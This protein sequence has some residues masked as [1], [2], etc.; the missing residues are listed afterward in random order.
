MEKPK[1]WQEEEQYLNKTVSMIDSRIQDLTSNVDK[2]QA[3]A[4]ELKKQYIHDLPDFDEAEFID[5]Y[6]K[7]DQM[8]SFIDDQVQHARQLKQVRD[9][10][11]FGRIDFKIADD[12]DIMKLYI[13]IMSIDYK[14][15]LYVI[16]W[17]APVSELF[18]EAGRGPASYE[19]P[20][21]VINGEIIL[22]RQHDIEKGKLLNVYD[23]NLNIFDEFL[24]QVLAKSKGE[25]LQNIAST[26][27]EEQNKIIRNLKDDVMVVQGYAGCGKTTI[28][29]HRI[30]YALYRLPNLSSAN[31]LMFSPNDAFLTYI[32]KVLPELGEDNTRNATF[33]KFVRR[34][35]K[36]NS[37]IESSDEF[38]SRYVFLSKEQQKKIDS[39]LDYSMREKMSNWLNGL[40]KSLL[41]KEGFIVEG[42]KYDA[43]V[44]NKLLT[45]DYKHARYVEKVNLVADY[46]CEKIGVMEMDKRGLIL[47]EIYQKLNQ[48]VKLEP[49]YAKFLQ[50]FKY[51]PLDI[52]NKI[53]FEDAVLMC[54]LKELSKDIV[55]K[56]DIKHVVV[57]EAQDYPLIFMDFLL[58]TCPHSMFS[59]FGDIHQKTVA[60]KLDSLEDITKLD[61]V[62][63]R[64]AFFE[65]DKTYRS[66][67]E[68]VE[69]A[70]NLIGNPRHN[71][72][73]LKNGHPV[74]EVQIAD[75]NLQIS[76][77]VM[78]ILEKIIAG[79]TTVGII[80]GDTET[81]KDIFEELSKVIAEHKISFVK[82]AYSVAETQV[83]VVP[84]AL[85]KGLE[86]DTVII[87]EKGKLF[88]CEGR[89]N[90]IFISATRAINRLFVLKN[91]QKKNKK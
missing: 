87:V 19:A 42:Q 40:N 58:R 21:G 35:L 34:F 47:D 11:Y 82:N 17:R 31:V 49:L 68:I 14:N 66:S 25:Q 83:Q 26:I 76:Q 15:E 63:N 88:E 36:T 78:D 75:N 54:V 44:L 45:E 32:N 29:L 53:N 77:Q 1:F 28:A 6:E 18:Y 3:W 79:K 13:G 27:Q 51:S 30:A 2:Q 62:K 10:P 12:E 4:L 91:K 20:N 23:I 43:D 70:S 7:L 9:K 57:D 37:A 8:L 85:S 60:G 55:L 22:K 41:F 56:M 67:E 38:V 24:Q 81:A 84:V 86:F 72:F 16:D 64:G 89:D 46:L 73:R 48:P 59:F 65:L 39:K 50:D 69:Y 71:A 33:P 80:T 61:I 52:D 5:N 74:E 90:F